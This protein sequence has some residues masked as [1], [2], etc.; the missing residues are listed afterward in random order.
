MK[1]R[2]YRG[3]ILQPQMM[4]THALK[5]YLLWS[6]ENVRYCISDADSRLEAYQKLLAQTKAYADELEKRRLTMKGRW[7]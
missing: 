4:T 2:A 7:S 1:P 3:K 6:R 5:A